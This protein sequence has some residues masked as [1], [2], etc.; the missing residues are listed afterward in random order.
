MAEYDPVGS[1]KQEAE[2]RKAKLLEAVA[3]AG[4]AGRQ[5]YE[6]AQQAIQ[7]EQQVALQ[8]ASERARLYN[9]DPSVGA[10]VVGSRYGQNLANLA[11][12]QDSFTKG[13]EGTRASG[14][15]YLEKLGAAFPMVQEQNRLTIAGREKEIQAAL[16]EAQAKAEAEAAQKAQEQQF[17]LER[18][19]LNDERADAR[20][21]RS[22]AASAAA[23][24]AKFPI[25]E[26]LGATQLLLPEKQAQAQALTNELAQHQ[27]NMQVWQSGSNTT[28]LVNKMKANAGRLNE[29][30][31]ITQGG[32]KGGLAALATVLPG[33]RRAVTS[34]K[35]VAKLKAEEQKLVA[36]QKQLQQQIDQIR[37]ANANALRG[38]PQRLA[39]L[40]QQAAAA[41]QL[42]DPV[43]LS[44][45]LG[46]NQF[47]QNPLTV[48]GKL[49]DQKWAPLLNAIGTN[50]RRGIDEQAAALAKKTN[51]K[52]GGAVAAEILAKPNVQKW[53]Q[54]AVQ[55]SGGDYTFDQ[56]K[57]DL[58]ADFLKKGQDRT[59]AILKELLAGY[60]WGKASK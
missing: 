55:L 40:Q 44:R 59:Y 31:K 30:N 56:I 38:A 43:A 42:T 7:G 54:D 5:S 50:D 35:E 12:M 60:A 1:A 32:L 57:K 48:Y 28:D 3:Q 33:G 2:D 13:L 58:D 29:I 22:D 47:G 4:T 49:T 9:V 45:D 18:D 51:I 8:R 46:I 15:S 16:A 53:I 10:D 26:I 6:Q 37:A 20:S 11:G 24:S 34:N 52:G 25:D 19:R 36:S 41:Q 23:T 14:V 21:A 39:E 17:L 27:K